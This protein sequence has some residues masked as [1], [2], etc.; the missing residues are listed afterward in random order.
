MLD[1][2]SIVRRESARAR[3]RALDSASRIAPTTIAVERQATAKI[4]S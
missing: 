2:V 1:S 3:M 4:T